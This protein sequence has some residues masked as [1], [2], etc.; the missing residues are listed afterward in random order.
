VAADVTGPPSPE[1][2]PGPEVRDLLARAVA[3][4]VISTGQAAAIT[5]LDTGPAAGPAPGGADGTTGTDATPGPRGPAP[6]ALAE[7]LGY[8]GGAVTL[9][10]ALVIGEQLWADLAAGARVGVLALVTAVTVVAGATLRSRPGAAGRLAGFSWL[11][12]VPAAAGLVGVAADQ[13]LGWS[14]DDAT[15]AAALVAAALAAV[16]WWL[17]PAVVGQ[18]AL[19]VALVVAVVT[20]ILRLDPSGDAVAVTVW[21]LGLAWVALAAARLIPAPGAAWV[22]GSIAAVIAPLTSA[23]LPGLMLTLGVLTAA[24]LLAVGVRLRHWPVVA[25]GTVGL[26]IGVPL[27]LGELFGTTLL[28]VWIALG[29]GIALLVA[30]V[31]LARR[32]P[33]RR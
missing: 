33:A 13:L 6:G 18:V 21:L 17:R 8:L 15:L 22:L 28:P 5:R 31:L 16:L 7:V 25:I 12:S 27:A 10:A 30:G 20:T 11:L 1:G 23:W 14:A 24:A 32:G 3:A 4:G 26:V 2:P 29:V 19:F 9:V